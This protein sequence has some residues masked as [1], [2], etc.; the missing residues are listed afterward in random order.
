LWFALVARRTD[1]DTLTDYP[2][3]YSAN[4]N[5]T[6]SGIGDNNGCSATVGTREL[7]AASENPGNFSWDASQPA[8]SFTVAI[9]PA[10]Q[11]GAQPKSVAP[12][13]FQ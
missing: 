6:L 3:N 13:F 5:H 7:N 1:G 2:T 8:V 12:L 10:E 9:E 11:P 4:Q